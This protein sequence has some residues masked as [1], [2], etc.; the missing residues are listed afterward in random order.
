[1]S[2]RLCTRCNVHVAFTT[3][4]ASPALAGE[5]PGVALDEWPPL[6]G[7]S[8]AGQIRLATDVARA[9]ALMWVGGDLAALHAKHR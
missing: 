8:L 7:Y 5:T 6:S 1:M 3:V 9:P 2:H 4:G